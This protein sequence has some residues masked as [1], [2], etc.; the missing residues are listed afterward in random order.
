M[1]FVT[2]AGACFVYRFSSVAALLRASVDDARAHRRSS[3][4]RALYIAGRWRATTSTRR[5][6]PPPPP[7]P[8]PRRHS[9]CDDDAAICAPLA[10]QQA[11]QAVIVVRRD[12]GADRRERRQRR[13]DPGGAD[14]P[15]RTAAHR[16]GQGTSRTVCCR[17]GAPSTAR[18]SSRRLSPARSTRRASLR[19]W[20]RTRRRSVVALDRR[21]PGA[22]RR[23][24]ARRR[25]RA[26]LRCILSSRIRLVDMLMSAERTTA[27][28]GRAREARVE[29]RS[30]GGRPHGDARR[31][32]VEHKSYRLE[33]L[34]SDTQHAAHEQTLLGRLRAARDEAAALRVCQELLANAPSPQGSVAVSSETALLAASVCIEESLAQAAGLR[35]AHARAERGGVRRRA[36]ARARRRAGAREGAPRPARG[37]PRVPGPTSA[38]ATLCDCSSFALAATPSARARRARLGRRARVAR[39]GDRLVC[40][41]NSAHRRRSRRTASAPGGARRVHVRAT[42][43]APAPPPHVPLGD[44]RRRRADDAAAWRHR[45]R[46]RWRSTATRRRLGDARARARHSSDSAARAVGAGVAHA[47]ARIRAI[48]WLEALLDARAHTLARRSQAVEELQRVQQLLQHELG[49]CDALAPAKGY[50]FEILNTRALRKARAVDET[51]SYCI[52]VLTL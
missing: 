36:G 42:A 32:A 46:Q 44:A 15:D 13:A 6:R 41:S 51:P 7:P 26:A 37:V 17:C 9:G 47:A 3:A 52:E 33:H 40:R 23:R 5:R 48:Q 25:P 14:Q 12:A 27:G 34:A 22:R 30:A 16:Q 35:G 11:R 38:G 43:L 1:A 39:R 31:V 20:S 19:R 10:P 28:G 21:R 45:R 18:C 29:R 24:A 4:S 50:L 49:I 2:A 8:P